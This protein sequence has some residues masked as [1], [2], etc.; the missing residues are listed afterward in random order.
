MAD[1]WDDELVRLDQDARRPRRLAAPQARRRSRRPALHPHRARR[2]LPL[3]RARGAAAVSLRTRL[4]ARARLR[5]AAGDRRARRPAR[6]SACATASTPRCARRRAGQADVVAATA[7]DLLGAAARPARRDARRAAPARR[8]RARADRRRARAWCWPTAPGPAAVGADY[9]DRPEIAPALR[10]AAAP[11]AAPQRHA[12]ATD[13]LATAV[14][15]VRG[16]R[17]RRR[18]AGHPER[19]GGRPRGARALGGPRADRAVVLA[20]RPRGRR[21][22]RRRAARG[23]CGA[24]RR[25]PGASPAATSSAR[26]EVEGSAEQRSLARSFNEMTE[27]L[28]DALERQRAVRRRRLAPAAHAADRRCGC[29]LEE[30]RRRAARRR[31]GRDELDAG[32][33]EVDRLARHRRRAAG[34]QPRRPDA[35]APTRAVDA[36]RR[37]EA[38]A[39]RFAR[40]ARPTAACGSS[41]RRR[42]GARACAR[43]AALDRALDAL[44]ENAIAYAPRRRGRS[45]IARRRRPDR[46]ARPRARASRRA[47]RRRSSSASTAAA[48]AARGA[49]GTGLGLADRPRARARLGRRG[50]ARQ[51]RDGGAR[52]VV[53]L[54]A[55]AATVTEVAAMRRPAAFAGWI[56]LALVGLVVA[57]GA[58]YAA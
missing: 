13:L 9:G 11:G 12:R 35:R 17:R 45:S 49:R 31:P 14:P 19:R 23:R 4:A 53:V 54:P 56:A 34:A 47:R 25:P 46:G 55:R 2:R 39:E 24:W 21:G 22:D 15:I 48:P 58:A 38:A 51:R 16:A 52:A 50:H 42:A 37:R 3:R 27:R 36:R 33:R 29:A 1:V 43:A 20:D 26:A 57:A 18:G 40:A 32:M 8:A 44:V 30:A 5:P 10:G 41:R 7:A 28:P 6:R